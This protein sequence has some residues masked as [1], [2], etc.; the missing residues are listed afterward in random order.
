MTSEAVNSI[1]LVALK[2][3]MD[4]PEIRDRL[5]MH[6]PMTGDN[7]N[8]CGQCNYQWPCPVERAK[9]VVFPFLREFN[10]R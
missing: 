7:C 3:L 10:D 8:R 5:L 9:L 2:D 6:F 4:L 1:A